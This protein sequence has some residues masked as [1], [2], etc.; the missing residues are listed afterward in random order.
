MTIRVVTPTLGA[1]PHLA[2]T[3]ASVRPFREDP[4]VKL[5]HLLAC[6]AG[7]AADLR[8]RFPD[9]EVVDEGEPAGLYAAVE[10]GLAAGDGCWDFCTYLNDDDVL[11]PGFAALLAAAGTASAE[12]ILYGDVTYLD[13]NG[14]PAGRMPVCAREQDLA[15]LWQAGI[16]PMTQQGTLIGHDAWK[17]AGGFDPGFR[18]AG[19]FAFWA[20]ALRAGVPFRHCPALV[21]GFRL[22]PGQLSADRAAM[23]AEFARVR[24][25]GLGPPAGRLRR[26]L[27]ILRFRWRHRG[28]YLRRLLRGGA[29]TSSERFGREA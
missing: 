8:R 26:A 2:E 1:S 17:A 14:G 28:I 19:D 13:T 29:L 4:G 22:R 18:L 23:E 25:A 5:V 10:K 16:T 15:P 20:A 3:V 9:L 21:A 12:A 11:L 7:Q 24:K 27:A 6:P